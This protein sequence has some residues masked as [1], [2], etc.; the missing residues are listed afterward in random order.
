MANR[1]PKEAILIVLPTNN[2]VQK[3]TLLT[4]AKPLAQDGHQVRV[5][6]SEEVACLDA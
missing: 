3:R 6:S 4:V 1:L 2:A 5:V